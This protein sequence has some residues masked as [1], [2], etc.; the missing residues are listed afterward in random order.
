VT[1]PTISSATGESLP[2]LFQ[3]LKALGPETFLNLEIKWPYKRPLPFAERLLQTLLR[4]RNPEN[5]LLTSFNP[6]VLRTLRRGG[7]PYPLGLIYGDLPGVPPFLR[8][9][10]GRWLCQ[11]EHLSVF[12]DN[13]L[14]SDHKPKVPY[15]VWT[16][17]DSPTAQQVLTAGASGVI[18]DQPDL[19]LQ[20][21]PDLLLSG[22]KP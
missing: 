20:E 2:I 7:S 5:T 22:S 17:N 8:K 3:A 14:Y 15:L 16:V 4:H 19:L 10:L 9:G 6:A 21:L 12:K 13:L 18:S 1:S 11:V